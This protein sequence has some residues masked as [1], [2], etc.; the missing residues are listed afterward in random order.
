MLSLQDKTV[1]KV[2]KEFRVKGRQNRST[3]RDFVHVFLDE[4]NIHK[5][6]N[7]FPVNDKGVIQIQNKTTNIKV[8]G[9]HGSV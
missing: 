2:R 9:Y 3:H 6:R 5:L 7:D 8:K 4:C 1:S